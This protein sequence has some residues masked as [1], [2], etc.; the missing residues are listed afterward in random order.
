MLYGQCWAD[1]QAAT[2][3]QGSGSSHEL[4]ALLLTESIHHSLLVSKKP[5]FV[6][7]LD[8]KSAF[9]KV[10]R[11]CA[12]RNAYLAGTTGQGLLYINS[13]LEHRKTLVEWD[14][15]L[16][17]PI[18]DSLGVEQGGVNSDRIYKLCNN[19]QLSTAQKSE[20]GVDIGS[21]VVSAIGQADDTALLSD[22][23]HKLAGLLHLTVE[24]CQKYHVELVAEK[25]KLLAYAPKNQ[26]L[27]LYLQEVLNPLTL[28]GTRIDFSSSAEH[29]GILRS[30]EGNM[31]NIL[32][33]LS[34]H[35]KAIMSI[36]PTGM[37]QGHRGNP[38][39]SLRLEKLY[40][41]PVLLSGLAALVLGDNETAVVHHHHKL[42]L[43]RLQRL[44]QATPECVVMFLA[45]SIPA[46]GI[47]HLR[48]FGLLGMIARLGPKNILHQHG[49]HILLS[50]TSNS[51]IDN[52]WFLSVRSL[53]QQYHLQ[54]PLL[55]LQSPPS[56]EQ[57]K[58]LCKS[59]VI[60][61]WEQKL[62][63][64]ADLL[65]S[66]LFFKANF[67]SL[68]NP[69]PIWLH[70]RSPFEVGKAVVVARMLSGR[71]KTDRLARHWT[72]ENPD[73][74]CRL[75]GCLNQEGNLQHILLHCSALHETRAKMISFWG[76][77]LVSKPELFPVIQHYTMREDHLLP[78]FLLDPSC[79]PLVISHSRIYPDTL[80]DCLFL[81]RT[82]CYAVHLARSK[83]QHA[84]NLR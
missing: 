14:K 75:P 36:L 46:S 49:R 78:Q 34:A 48:I 5:L 53:C 20:L 13:R 26:K 54:D 31:P 3:F 67:M 56:P 80:Q 35:T 84:M 57:W 12:V 52:S 64:E 44:C 45:G 2:Q 21:G 30:V 40:G 27:E 1:A 32:S 43:Q 63:A 55:V 81:S 68:S 76:A 39:A 71:Y 23:L 83:L 25:T 47:L 29:V 60:D 16:M 58:K 8:A 37:A 73:G 17:G 61:F 82:W 41:T 7:M 33:R 22:S 74:L 62:R 72:H 66:L 42:N 59:K 15:V 50:A 77:F 70:A 9:D 65:P 10:V 11:E 38:A 18:E 19:V 28:N 79:L 51:K 24:Y 4:A 6:L 69:H